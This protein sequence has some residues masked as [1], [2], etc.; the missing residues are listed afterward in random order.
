MRSLHF[1]AL[2]NFKSLFIFIISVGT[3]FLG[4]GIAHYVG[5]NFQS[6]DFFLGLLWTICLVL[7]GYS[8][9][10]FYSP[11]TFFS[12]ID[13]MVEWVGKNKKLFLILSTSLLIICGM[14]VVG[15]LIRKSL[16]NFQ[17][18]LYLLS[19]IGYIA[20]IIPPFNL[21]GKGYLEIILSIFQAGITTALGY[22]SVFHFYQNILLFV[23]FPLTCIALASY[24][25]FGFSTYA[26]DL[27]IE[28]KTFLRALSWQKAIPIHNILL[29]GSYVFLASGVIFHFPIGIVWPA[30]L[31]FP[32]GCLQGLWLIRIKNGGKPVWPFFNTLITSV[33]GLTV[34][35]LVLTFWIK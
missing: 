3:Y 19:I 13:G 22:F 5:A 7:S 26:N 21:G 27:K 12:E 15:Q 18:I 30:L 10:I 23:S 4:G 34:Y 8:L 14:V 29:I 1:R 28:R 35:F 31:T 33:Y 32:L 17:E 25:A 24:L 2:I 6:F 11:S 20:L 9:R 16:S